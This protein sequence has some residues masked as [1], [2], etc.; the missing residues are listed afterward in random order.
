MTPSPIEASVT[1]ARS[2]SRNSSASAFLTRSDIANGPD[3]RTGGE[4]QPNDSGN[5]ERICVRKKSALAR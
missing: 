4:D 3:A 2:F 5:A 1:C